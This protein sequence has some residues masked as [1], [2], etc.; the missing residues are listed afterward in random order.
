MAIEYALR[1]SKFIRYDGTNSEEIRAAVQEWWNDSTLTVTGA[2]STQM[3]MSIDQGFRV[4]DVAMSTGDRISI[5]EATI[6]S[7]AEWASQYVKP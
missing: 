1:A 2:D 7:P 5:S 3:A 6:I 4:L